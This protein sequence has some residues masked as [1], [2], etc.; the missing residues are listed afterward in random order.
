MSA[1]VMEARSRG[2]LGAG[3]VRFERRTD[4]C[5]MVTPVGSLGPYPRRI[6]ERLEYWAAI[7]PD[8]ALIAR[9]D[10]A[11]RG[12]WRRVSYAE[13]LRQV[14]ALGQA[15]LDRGLSAE[16][17]LVIL[18]GNCPEQAALTLAALHV[19]VP[20]APVSPSYSTLAKDF[21]KLR[22]CIG[23]LTPGLVFAN[24]GA[25]FA[26]AIAAAVPAGIELVVT[27]NPPPGRAATRLDELLATVPTA[28]VEV[29]AAA[30]DPDA[31]A[32]ILFTSGSTGQPK[33]VINTQR[34]LCSNQ[35]MLLEAFPFMGGEP[36]VLLDWLPWHHTFGGNHNIGLCSTMA[37]RSTWTTGARCPA[38]SRRA[39][40]T[41]ARSRP[42]STLTS[43]VASRRWCT[44]WSAMRACG[45]TS[46]PACT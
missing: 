44:T 36:P 26:D 45:G 21:A 17:P 3:P 2:K 35:Q 42:P 12:D 1:P 16:R 25:R 7:A 43:H 38:A 15:L 4:G 9:R 8:R 20:V 40:A 22:H 14:R 23:L 31:P 18:S 11:L 10:P 13:M 19:G 37:E 5:L 28:G 33:G 39:S 46:S 30:V 24:D 41:C 32:K 6:T 29:A 27:E 34:M